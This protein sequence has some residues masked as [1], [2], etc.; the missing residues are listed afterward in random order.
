LDDEEIRAPVTERQDETEAHDHDEPVNAHGVF[1][2]VTHV[3]PGFRPG[4][5]RIAMHGGDWDQLFLQGRPAADVLQR[6]EHQRR[7]AE[8]DH[9]ELQHLVVNGGGEPA[10]KDIDQHDEGGGPDAG[11]V[12]PMDQSLE[13]P[14]Q[15]VQGNA[16]G[17]DRH[18]RE[19]DGV[20]AA[21]LF[22]EAQ[23]EI[24]RHGAGLRAV[25]EGHHE[26][27]EEDHR[28]DGSD[29]VKMAGHDAVLGAGGGHADHLLRAEIGGEKS[30]ACDPRRDRAPRKEE[31]RAALHVALQGGADADDE[32]EV[33]GE[34]GVID[35][36]ELNGDGHGPGDGGSH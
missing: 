25:V 23:L 20:E 11:P 15:R 6:Q 30:E 7:E 17:K 13:Q 1:N 34:Q 14:G 28:G 35:A 22:V 26:D 18:H 29:P 32:N 36:A 16:R 12:V 2:G 5:R 9:E 33:D 21:R 8:D 31:I 27:G 3:R 10:E 4:T 19:G 24:L